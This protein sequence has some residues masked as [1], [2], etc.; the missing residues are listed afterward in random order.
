MKA[1]NIDTLEYKGYTGTVEFSVPDKC[2]HGRVLGISHLFTFEGNTIEE[3]EEDFRRCI[4]DYLYDCEQ[5]NSKP[6]EPFSGTLNIRIG[7]ELHKNIVIQARKKGETLNSF[8]KETLQ[9]AIC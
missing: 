3:L 1:I 6:Q 8:I 4:D 2:F 7:A 5:E 9:K